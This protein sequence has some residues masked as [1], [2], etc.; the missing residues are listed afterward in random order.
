MADDVVSEVADAAETAKEFLSL[1]TLVA[2]GQTALPYVLKFLTAFV[3]VW[4]GF[5]I[6]RWA[7]K[8]AKKSLLKAPNVDETLDR[9]RTGEAGHDGAGLDR[10]QR[11]HAGTALGEPH[12]FRRAVIACAEARAVSLSGMI[13]RIICGRPVERSACTSARPESAWITGS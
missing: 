1:D 2:Y 4:I 6:A 11:H 13:R 9:Q 8:V 10:S 5:K 12:G 3:V 7:G